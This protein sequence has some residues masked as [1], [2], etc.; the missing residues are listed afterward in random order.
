MVGFML[1]REDTNSLPNRG[2]NRASD[3]TGM[4]G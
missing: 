3:R 1:D 2:K 4:G